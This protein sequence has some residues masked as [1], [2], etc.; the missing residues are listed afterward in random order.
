[1]GLRIGLGVG[2]CDCCG[3][4]PSGSE[5][6]ICNLIWKNTNS[7]ETELT[8]GGSIP[9]AT[10]STEWTN[11]RANSTPIACY[12]NFDANN[13]N[14]GLLYNYYAIDLVKPPSGFRLA[15]VDD[16]LE[17]SCALS[18]NNNPLGANPGEW[19]P[20]VLTNTAELGDTGLDI[21]GYGYGSFN[22][23]SGTLQFINFGLWEFTWCNSVAPESPLR[24]Y[25]ANSGTGVLQ[26]G[27]F[28][29]SVNDIAAFIRFAKDV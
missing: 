3:G 2:W 20:S 1:M 10:N 23:I 21:Q 27:G 6:E 17:L 11:A 15:T 16:Y 8:A 24:G 4:S 29:G 9:I 26:G 18:G 19:D 14:Y 13:S 12:W 22:T 25:T 7:S 28:G 5:V